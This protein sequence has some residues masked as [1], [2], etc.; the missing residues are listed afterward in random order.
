MLA[1][2]KSKGDSRR[3]VV[4]NSIRIDSAEIVIA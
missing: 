3:D 1:A 4:K 2:D